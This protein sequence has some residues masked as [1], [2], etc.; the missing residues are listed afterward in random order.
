MKKIMSVDLEPD[1]NSTNCKSVTEVV[2]KLLNFFDQ[3]EIRATFFTVTSLLDKFESEIKEISKKHEIASHSQTHSSL[4]PVNASWEIRT[5]KRKLEE[6][7]IKCFGF[8]APRFIT[9]KNHFD[10]LKEHGYSYDASLA[11]Y[12]PGRYKNKNLMNKPYT[13]NGMQTFPMTTFL[14]MVNSGLSYLKLLH[15]LSNIF[16]KP[17]MFYLH[18]WEFLE[19]SSLGGTGFIAKSLHRNSGKKAWKIFKNYIDNSNSEWVGCKDWM[20]LN[21]SNP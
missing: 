13:L 3:H 18:P 14:P 15:P 12:F 10:L 16:K 6:H 17:Y 2:P 4:N 7:G 9:T 21:N 1:L 19:K 5:S 11:K 20:E 8:R